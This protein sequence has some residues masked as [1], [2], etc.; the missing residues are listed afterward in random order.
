MASGEHIRSLAGIRASREEPW[1]KA[2]LGVIGYGLTAVIE[3]GAPGDG[4][5]M[6]WLDVLLGPAPFAALSL[7]RL[8]LAAT[9][10]LLGGFIRGFVGFGGSLVIVLLLSLSFGPLVAVPVASL[11][12]LPSTL[13]LLPAAVRH[14]ERSFVLPFVLAVFVVAPVGALVLVSLDPALMKIAIALT[15]LAM[16]ALLYRGWRPARPPGMAMLLGIGV[17][18]GLVQGAAGVGGPPA[19]AMALSRSGSAE[20]QRGNVIGAVTALALCNLPPLWLHGLYTRDVVLLS[21][22]VAPLYIGA[23]WLGARY[24][25]GQGRAHFRPAALLILAAIGVVT[26]ALSVQDFW[27]G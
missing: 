9:A 27:A 3:R 10:A 26:L 6:D 22:L 5:V 15:V 25:A 17:A 12:G 21:L 24:F 4:Q 11:A 14:A 23:T 1:V 16:V 20:R 2:H 7:A 18:A 13:Q 8:A 19:V